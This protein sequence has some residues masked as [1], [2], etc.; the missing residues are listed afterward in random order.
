MLKNSLL[1]AD[2]KSEVLDWPVSV[3]LRTKWLWV[4]VQLQSLTRYSAQPRDTLFVKGS[5]FLS[6]SKNMGK[7]NSKNLSSKCSQELFDHA[8]K[9]ATDALKT[10]SKRALQKTT[11]ATGGLICNKIDY[12]ITKVFTKLYILP[13]NNSVAK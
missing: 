6:F 3:H 12:R 10:S 2:V 7:N 5:G 1:E 13:Q 9:S 4:R 8:E 11:E